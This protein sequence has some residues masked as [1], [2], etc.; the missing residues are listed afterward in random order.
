MLISL[1]VDGFQCRCVFAVS[2]TSTGKG[3]PLLVP[4]SHEAFWLLVVISASL[5]APLARGGVPRPG[6]LWSACCIFYLFPPS[7]PASP[8]PP[9]HHLPPEPVSIS[10]DMEML[11]SAI[12]LGKQHFGT[13]PSIPF[14]S[15]C[16]DFTG[17]V[18]P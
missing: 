10:C 7:V 1:Q 4:A 15:A 5:L 9:I 13:S 2:L 16:S 6:S 18:P 3:N 14:K 11:D 17:A 12:F 8:G